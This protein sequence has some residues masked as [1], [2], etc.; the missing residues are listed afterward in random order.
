MSKTELSSRQETALPVKTVKTKNYTKSIEQMVRFNPSMGSF[1]IV[2][3]AEDSPLTTLYFSSKELAEK[4]ALA[5]GY[6]KT[7]TPESLDTELIILLGT[8]TTITGVCSLL[9]HKMNQ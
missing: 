9:L 6:T 2:E 8:I 5:L 4:A 1:V 3:R 7:W